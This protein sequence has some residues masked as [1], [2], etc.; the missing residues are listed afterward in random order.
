MPDREHLAALRKGHARNKD[1]LDLIDAIERTLPIATL[2]IRHRT[3][4]C[5]KTGLYFREPM[6]PGLRAH[7][8]KLIEET[9][10]VL[11]RLPPAAE[12]RFRQACRA[13][14]DRT[15]Y[16]MREARTSL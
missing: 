2:K 3:L 11:S 10:P 16:E 13:I 8:M 7:A 12:S 9:D 6:P 14:I 15:E 5:T 4:I 1:V